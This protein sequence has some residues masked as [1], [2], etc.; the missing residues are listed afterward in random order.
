MNDA[1][2][3]GRVLRVDFA[4]LKK[5]KEGSQKPI[6]MEEEFHRD[7]M[8]EKEREQKKFK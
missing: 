4:K 5:F 8:S 2:L 7:K 3:C 6:W 1:E